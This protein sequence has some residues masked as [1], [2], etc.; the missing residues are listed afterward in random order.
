[1]AAYNPYRD[2]VNQKLYFARL[3]L[4]LGVDRGIIPDDGRNQESAQ[5]RSLEQALFEGAVLHLGCAYR[6]YLQEV[7]ENYQ[8]SSES[9]VDIA[10]L[11]AAL[12]RI[13]KTPGEVQ[14]LVNLRA[15][16]G[17][18]LGQLLAVLEGQNLLQAKPPAV[19]QL[20]T[21]DS[22]ASIA[23]ITLIEELLP[24]LNAER[25]MAWHGAFADL[26]ERQR[27]LMTEC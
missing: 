6:L 8:C 4:T 7:A 23:A 24:E 22:G 15:D 12:A 2:R 17:S 10:T 1:M 20:S 21:S 9:V 18:W 25:I 14:E 26:V 11:S 13:N 5:N 3:L 19:Q 27:E 16:V